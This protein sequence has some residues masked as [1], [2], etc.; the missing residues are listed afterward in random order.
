MP[1]HGAP[2]SHQAVDGKYKVHNTH[3][4]M[5]I[6]QL[7]RAFHGLLHFLDVVICCYN[8]EE[9]RGPAGTTSKQRRLANIFENR[10]LFWTPSPPG[11]PR[12]PFGMDDL[13]KFLGCVG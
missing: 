10:C 8:T 7:S 2:Q 4:D 12:E 5:S 11:G 6:V 9:A 1:G 13:F 3:D